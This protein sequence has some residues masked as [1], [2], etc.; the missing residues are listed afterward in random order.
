MCNYKLAM[1]LLYRT[2]KI[3]KIVDNWPGLTEYNVG[4]DFW[5]KVNKMMTD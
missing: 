4:Y 2:G 5:E 1:Q 3:N